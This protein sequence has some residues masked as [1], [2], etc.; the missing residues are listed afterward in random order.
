MRRT[1]PVVVHLQPQPAVQALVSWIAALASAGLV[2][3]LLSLQ[4]VAWPAVMVAS[5][6][7]PLV[8]WWASR[9]AAVLPRRLRWDGEAWWLDEPGRDDG[10][11][12]QLAVLV[13]LDAW[14]LLRASPGP[15]WLPL[16]RRQQQAQWTALRATLFCAPR[17]LR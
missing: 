13:D 6:A 9:A 8:A 10:P 4:T 15:R 14:L 1:P 2:A 11:P 7:V 12:V 17:A 5:L 16:S 3:W